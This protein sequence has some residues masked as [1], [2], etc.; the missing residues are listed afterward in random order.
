MK[1]WLIVKEEHSNKADR[2]FGNTGVNI[3]LDGRRH[4]GAV[5]RQ[6]TFVGKYVD[7]Q[8]EKWAGQVER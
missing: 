7:E 6:D 1:T 5:I 4:L 2:L 8:V 3:T